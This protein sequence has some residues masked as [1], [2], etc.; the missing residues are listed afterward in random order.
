M[1]AKASA[2]KKDVETRMSVQVK[3]AYGRMNVATGTNE[4]NGTSASRNWKKQ[5]QVKKQAGAKKKSGK[6]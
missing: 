1:L 5:S 6:G 4:K 3:S 2:V